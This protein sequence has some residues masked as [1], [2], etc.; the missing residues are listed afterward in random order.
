MIRVLRWHI[1]RFYISERAKKKK[2]A[3][4][5]C[6]INPD[7]GINGQLNLTEMIQHYSD[8]KTDNITMWKTSQE[9]C[10]KG[11]A[12]EDKL[13]SAF[14]NRYKS[15]NLQEPFNFKVKPNERILTS[16]MV[17]LQITD[18]ADGFDKIMANIRKKGEFP[19]LGKLINL[20][21][22]VWYDFTLQARDMAGRIY[23]Q[24]LAKD[25]GDKFES[26]KKND[27]Q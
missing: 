4:V 10:I 12:K 7:S 13:I 20:K 26:E 5:L 16:G 15:L 1:D 6:T 25:T 19:K 2:P 3:S 18:R 17:L 24:V 22:T 23:K 11:F 21:K 14:L 9:D 8:L 27:K